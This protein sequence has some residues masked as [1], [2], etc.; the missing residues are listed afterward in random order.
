[1]GTRPEVLEN[2]SSDLLAL[3]GFRVWSD[4]GRIDSPVAGARRSRSTDHR[5]NTAEPD[6]ALR[7]DPW[8]RSAARKTVVI[9]AS[10]YL[11]Q[12]EHI[13]RMVPAYFVPG[14]S[15]RKLAE[16]FFGWTGV[17]P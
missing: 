10:A 5:G 12:A 13:D 2:A 17:V 1:M 8:A 15:T 4:N 11:R 14:L 7:S 3:L 9:T 16:A 6:S